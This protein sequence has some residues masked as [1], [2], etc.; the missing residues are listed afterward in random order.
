MCVK[1]KVISSLRN[2]KISGFVSADRGMSVSEYILN[3]DR[4]DIRST[5]RRRERVQD[6]SRKKREREDAA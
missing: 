3:K 6:K 2:D 4:E 5:E 1:K